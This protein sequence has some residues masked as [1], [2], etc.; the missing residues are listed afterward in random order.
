M[1]SPPLAREDPG[2][3]PGA[4]KPSSGSYPF[5]DEL[6]VISSWYVVNDHYG[7]LCWSVWSK[8]VTCGLYSQRP[9]VPH[10]DSLWITRA[11]F[12]VEFTIQ[13]LKSGSLMFITSA[14]LT[15]LC[16]VQIGRGTHATLQQQLQARVIQVHVYLSSTTHTWQLDAAQSADCYYM[17]H[18]H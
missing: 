8:M 16:A 11:S 6:K 15:K 3:I 7:G 4:G 18:Q 17:R 12:A 2:L 14:R 10:A 5:R 9:H 13:Q 1:R